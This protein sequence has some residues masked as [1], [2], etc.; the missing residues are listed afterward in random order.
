MSKYR[1]SLPGGCWIRSSPQFA[2][3]KVGSL[4]VASPVEVTGEAQ[5]G[6]YPIQM[7]VHGSV[8]MPESTVPYISQWSTTAGIITS[9]CGETCALML[10]QSNGKALDKTVDDCV[11]L[12]NNY[13]GYTDANDLCNLLAFLGLEG[14]QTHVVA[15]RTICLIDYSL[16]P[17]ELKQDQ[18]YKGY[19]WAIC[20]SVAGGEVIY[21]DPDFWGND[22]W[23]GANKRV[24]LADFQSWCKGVYVCA[25]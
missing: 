24:S 23:K 22:T 16:V 3:N 9:D 7:W 4:L 1:V 19:H 6:F 15:E 18:S 13:D 17:P 10:A 14:K 25:S 20:V 8:L 2:E 5:N 21:H 12:L 11:R